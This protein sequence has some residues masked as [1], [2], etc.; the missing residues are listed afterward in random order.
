MLAPIVGP[1]LA[2]IDTAASFDE[3]VNALAPALAA[4][5]S[6]ELARRLLAGTFATRAL[7]LTAPEPETPGNV[8]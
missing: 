3:A 1:L 5:D 8:G 4:M 6:D 7:N 2:A